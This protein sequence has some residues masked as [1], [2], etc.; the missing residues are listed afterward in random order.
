MPTRRSL[1]GL[2]ALSPFTA[3]PAASSPAGEPAP[4]WTQGEPH[5]IWPGPA[6]GGERVLAPA[7]TGGE[8]GPPEPA[9]L[10]GVRV[11]AVH[12][13]RPGR[14]DGRAVLVIPGGAYSFV[15][16][17]NEGLDVARRFTASGVTVLVLVYRLPGEGWTPRAD[18]PLQDAQRAMRWAR[19][20]ERELG[21]DGA[22][23]GVL[24]F[25]AGGHLAASLAVGHEEEIHA[26]VD[27]IDRL[28][29]RPRYCGLVY[30]VVS[31]LDP[32]THRESRTLLLGPEFSESDCRR[33][34]PHLH[35]GPATPPVFLAHG[36][37][38]SAVP[39]ENSMMMMEAMRRA[40]RP[41][42]AHFFEHAEHAFALGHPGSPTEQW[43]GQ[44]LAWAA[45]PA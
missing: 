33:R 1:L 39:V 34:S 11:P 28:S 18:V 8:G 9:F 41:V 43:P 5:P 21:I 45:E 30:P 42:E 40:S 29:A 38:D 19:A 6:P 10:R 27:A 13:F 15:S 22:R 44:F 2:A 17:A 37:D 14:A 23:I 26:P 25:S 12:V 3:M 4:L 31:L 36:M 35:V 16:I 32:W 20:H 7:A 24:G